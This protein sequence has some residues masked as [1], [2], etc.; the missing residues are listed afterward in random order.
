MTPD[1]VRF[2]SPRAPRRIYGA[3][4][5]V[6]AAPGGAAPERLRLLAELRSRLGLERAE[7]AALERASRSPGALQLGAGE[8]ERRFLRHALIDL[9]QAGP[10]LDGAALLVLRRIVA[11][12][13]PRRGPF[14][15]SGEGPVIVV[16]R[17]QKCG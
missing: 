17:A 6:L 15:P 12:L 10:P 11:H 13:A 5:R 3:L 1:V 16:P 2:D 8:A 7:A 4:C 14:E 9:S